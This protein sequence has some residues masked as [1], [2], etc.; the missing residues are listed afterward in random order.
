MGNGNS[1]RQRQGGIFA[2]LMLLA[3][4]F[5]SSTS[6]AAGPTLRFDIPAGDSVKSLSLFNSQSKIEMLYI[7][8]QVQGRTTRAISGEMEITEALKQL[9]DGTDLEFEFRNDYT[10]VFIKPR[11]KKE[12]IAGVTVESAPPALTA[13]A[14][15]D[16]LD[17][18]RPLDEQDLEEVVIT[19]TL[20]HGV[21]DI[22]SPLSV[23]TRKRHE[24][25][26]L[27]DRCRTRC[28][29]LPLNFGG[30]PSEDAGGV[31][32]FARGV[33]V[34]L[35]GLGAGATL[36]LINGHRQPFSGT[37]G[38]FVDLSNI[39]W[40]A[41]ERIEVLPDGA[42][43]TYGSDAIAGVVNVIMRDD[44]DGAETQVRFG[45]APGGAKERLIGQLFG[46]KWS[47]GSALFSYQYSERTSL[48]A[49][50]RS[51]AANTDKTS[52]GGSDFRTFT[53]SPGNILDPLTQVPAFAIPSGQ[54]GT[55]LSVAT[56]FPTRSIC[57]TDTPRCSSCR[58]N[59]RTAFS[60]LRAQDLSERLSLFAEGRASQRDMNQQLN[61]FDT[62]LFVPMSN[63][64]VANVNPYP[65]VPFV[66]VG[67]NFLDDF[68][69]IALIFGCARLRRNAWAQGFHGLI[70]A[71]D[72]VRVLRAGDD[73]ISA[74]LQPTESCRH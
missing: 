43:A 36:V 64:Y 34:N 63:P 8:D 25:D 33:A 51:Y 73:P 58:T 68:G 70:L 14:R 11:P 59:A 35:R 47:S 21:L 40:S 57:R 54:D 30:G 67:Y 38:D 19:G 69:P 39:P 9:L 65:G 24:A 17:L 53:S 3:T 55:S 45:T 29:V 74:R 61:G 49:G 6:W 1:R 28:A 42:S 2:L 26:G 44:L 10:F 32:N 72:A 62:V 15:R 66:L 20:M 31:G 37:Q 60:L 48:A 56:C 4:S 13:N 18:D 7:T 22:M 23:V 52:L 12:D 46:T 5:C 41:V 27:C 16:L 50:E 71:N